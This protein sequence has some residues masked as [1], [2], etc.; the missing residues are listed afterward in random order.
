MLN[1]SINN[2]KNGFDD[3]TIERD[4]IAIINNLLKHPE[5][6]KN[7]DKTNELEIQFSNYLDTDYAFGFFKNDLGGIA[8]GGNFRRDAWYVYLVGCSNDIFKRD[9][10]WLSRK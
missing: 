9:I 4:D 3:A 6:K 1:S 2:L 5:N 10:Y 8:W 7:S